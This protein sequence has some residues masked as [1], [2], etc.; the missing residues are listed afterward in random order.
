[1]DGPPLRAAS[2]RGETLTRPE[3][4]VALEQALVDYWFKFQ[5]LREGRRGLSSALE[6][7]DIE[8]GRLST[9][10]PQA[11][12]QRRRLFDPAFG[13]VQARSTPR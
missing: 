2:E 12:G 8:G 1:L 13:K 7:R 5:R 3:A 9:E 6:W 4:E 10:F 11:L